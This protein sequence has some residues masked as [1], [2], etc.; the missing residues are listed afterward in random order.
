MSNGW[1]GIPEENTYLNPSEGRYML[2]TDNVDWVQAFQQH[3]PQTQVAPMPDD[4]GHVVYLPFHEDT[5]RIMDNLGWP[6]QGIQPFH[7]YYQK[8]KIEGRFD[9][10]IHQAETAAFMSVNKRCYC[11]NTMRTGKTGSLILAFDYLKRIQNVSGSALIVST[12]ST[13]GGVWERTLKTTLRDRRI[14]KVHGGSGKKERLKLLSQPADFYIINYDG[15]KIVAD[16]LE[17]MVRD[18]RI[19][20]VGV[21]ELTHYGNPSS[22]RWQALNAAINNKRRPCEYVCGMTG[23]PGGNSEAVF[24]MV[25]MITPWT[26]GTNSKEHWKNMVMYKYGAETW[27]WKDKPEAK[28]IIEKVL[29]PQIRFDKNDILEL[30]P[31][32]TLNKDA[33]LSKEQ[34]YDYVQMLNSMIAISQKG[35]VISAVSKAAMLH[36]L[37]QIA[38]GSVINDIGEIKTYD[39]T[40]RL[41]TI[42]ETIREAETKVVIFSIYKAAVTRLAQQLN[43]KGVSA[44]YVHGSVTGA[45]RDKIF[46]NFLNAPEPKVLVCHPA[47]TAFGTELAS[48]D[49]I[50]FDGPPRV[51]EFIYS[52][53]LERLSSL[54]Q[55]ARQISIVKL[56]ATDEE[57]DAFADIDAGVKSAES[58]NRIFAELTKGARAL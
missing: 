20:M 41:Q 37:F 44:A 31:V 49:T 58:V 22:G 46:D 52:Q 27:K 34:R 2:I 39:N 6:T 8:P 57:R 24:G 4:G 29:Q 18:G 15:V 50:I 45:A 13:L 23:S 40:P 10:M 5:V 17:D 33:E 54:K 12:V 32:V 42:L 38:L 51:G 3:V 53:A 48:A 56:S 28:F 47:T 19:N 25:K 11:F 16:E 43:D 14:V 36:K 7:F 9:S 1:F 26:I 55:K 21:D 30:P 35:E